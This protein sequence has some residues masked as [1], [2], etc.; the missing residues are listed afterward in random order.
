M[1][2]FCTGLLGKDQKR[3]KRHVLILHSYHDNMSWVKNLNRALLK[4]LNSNE[5]LFYFEYMDTKRFH[6]NEYFQRLKKLYSFKY[7][8][9]DFDLVIVAD[10]NAYD[11]VRKNNMP[12]FAQVPIVFCGVNFYN[13]KD[14]AHMKNITGVVERF[15]LMGTIKIARKNHPSAKKIFIVN[16]HLKTGSVWT[17]SM[18][19]IIKENSFDMAVEFAEDLPFEKLLKKIESLDNN[20]ILLLGVY[21]GDSMGKYYTYETIGRKIAAASPVPVYCLLEFNVGKGVIG[22]SVIS[23]YYQGLMSALIGKQILNG[24][25]IKTIPVMTKGSNQ[26]IFS[27][28]DLKR[29]QIKETLLPE[30]SKIIDR[31]KSIIRDH[32]SV[33]ITTL[34]FIMAQTML[35]FYL[36]VNIRKRRKAE[37]SLVVINKNLEVIVEERTIDL[38]RAHDTLKK[39]EEQYRNIVER[40]TEGIII[41]DQ[42]K[43]AFAN[44][45]FAEMV[46]YDLKDILGTE[47]INLLKKDQ[48]EMVRAIYNKR[49]KG[50]KSPETYETIFV[51]SEG[52]DIYVE[53][54]AGLVSINDK[55]MDFVFVRN[56]SKRKKYEKMV[57]ERNQQLEKALKDIETI[58][59]IVPICA[60][61]KSIRDDEGYWH[62]LEQY[63]E[64]H[65]LAEFSHGLCKSCADELYGDEDWYNDDVDE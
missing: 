45:Y 36:V 22:G 8:K 48:H 31:P 1:L 6:S 12:I 35:I 54:N 10:N 24:K 30:K 39:S 18:K 16:D 59:G 27:Y 40:A 41:I 37:E 44:S 61:C 42:E 52:T 32:L 53:I 5:I 46:G 3:D 63:I 21:F 51:N 19:R 47:V 60:K 65:S 25:D 11:F 55:P 33:I 29:F 9:I 50:E 7:N 20:T 26:Y 15:D 57:E 43:L 2:F 14:T 23:G 58:R 62:E 49:M 4:V 34:L 28:N 64:K 17:Q 38:K 13:P 56:I